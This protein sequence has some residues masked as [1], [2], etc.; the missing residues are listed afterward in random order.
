MRIWENKEWSNVNTVEEILMI[1]RR[2]DISLSVNN[3]KK[4][5]KTNLKLTNKKNIDEKI[6][7]MLIFFKVFNNLLIYYLDF[8]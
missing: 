8:F 7:N 3:N 4:K 6:I 5:I 1:R 2:K